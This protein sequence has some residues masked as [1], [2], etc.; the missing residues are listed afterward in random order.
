MQQKLKNSFIRYKNNYLSKK[1]LFMKIFLLVSLSFLNAL[2]IFGQN[3]PPKKLGAN[4]VSYHEAKGYFLKNTVSITKTKNL[5][6]KTQK[7]F[8]QYFGIGKVMGTDQDN[9][10][11]IDFNKEVVIAL[12]GK[13]AHT[14]DYFK[15]HSFTRIVYLKMPTTLTYSLEKGEAI[16]YTTNVV[17][18]LI[19]KKSDIGQLTF[20]N[21]TK[22]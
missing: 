16:S 5:L 15:I 20:K 7:E 8:D 14:M 12:I 2:C 9:P 19:V 6:I 13:P 1:N 11:S 22:K 4:D 18:V 3:E 21:V 10:T 17:S